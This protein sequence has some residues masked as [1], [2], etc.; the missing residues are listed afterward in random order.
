MALTMPCVQLYMFTDRHKAQCR[1]AGGAIGGW[2][3]CNGWNGIN[4]MGSTMWFPYV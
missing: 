2:A 4:E 3:H 1:L